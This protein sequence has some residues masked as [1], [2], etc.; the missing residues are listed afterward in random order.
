MGVSHVFLY[1]SPLHYRVIPEA[2]LRPRLHRALRLQHLSRQLCEVPNPLT[3]TPCASWWPGAEKLERRG[4]QA[5]RGEVRHPRPGG[6]GVTETAPVLAVNTPMAAKTGTV[7]ASFSRAAI[8]VEPVPGI[9]E[10]AC[11]T[12]AP[13][14]MLGYSRRAAGSDPAHALLLAK[15][16]TTP[17]TWPRST[18]RVHPHPGAVRRFAKVAERWSRWNWSS[19][20]PGPLRRSSRR[21]RRLAAAGAQRP[22]CCSPRTPTWPRAVAAGRAALGAPGPGMR[23]GAS[24]MATRSRSGLRKKDYVTLN[25]M[26]ARSNR[27]RQD[28]PASESD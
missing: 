28:L 17:E 27:Q 24:S 5:V 19:A 21:L 22:S 3:S 18:S 13:N 9:A 26:G 7:G 1:V 6:Y 14:V 2:D 16:G 10:A 25:R 4:A 15:A 23:H 12:C 11:C 8:P 20:L